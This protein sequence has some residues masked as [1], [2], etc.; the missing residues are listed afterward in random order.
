MTTDFQLVS[1][2]RVHSERLWDMTRA[3][4]ANRQEVNDFSALNTAHSQFL[5][6]LSGAV[7][8]RLTRS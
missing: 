4:V 3:Q 1:D 5:D 2:T 8:L 6:G 7:C